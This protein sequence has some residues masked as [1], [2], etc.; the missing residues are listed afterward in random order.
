[1]ATRECRQT[2][3]PSM[4]V[5]AKATPPVAPRGPRMRK[6]TNSRRRA[7]SVPLAQVTKKLQPWILTVALWNEEE[8]L[9]TGLLPIPTP[10]DAPGG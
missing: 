8:C 6:A 1:M 3:M 10:N 9:S 2:F 5:P 7:P 4:S